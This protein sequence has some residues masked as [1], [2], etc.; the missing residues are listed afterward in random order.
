MMEISTGV[1]I[2][3]TSARVRDKIWERVVLLCKNGSAVMVFPAANEQG[4]KFQIHGETWEPIDFDGI[5][6]MLRPSAF[7]LKQI[8]FQKTGFSNAAKLRNAKKRGTTVFKQKHCTTPASYTVIDVETTGL[9]PNTDDIIEIGAIKIKDSLKVDEFNTLVMAHK[10]IPSKVTEITGITQE[11]INT[12]GVPISD[13]IAKTITFIGNLPIVCHNANFDRNFIVEACKK[14]NIPF[15][16]T[17]IDTLIL[18]RS[19]I[20]GLI[21]YKLDTLARHFSII[22]DNPHRSMN[23]CEVTWQLYEKLIKLHQE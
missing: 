23:D 8:N 20:K 18:A 17:T 6:L 9:N 12:L 5:K 2:G 7:R 14:E 10:P 19:A 11:K 22:N 15:E 4:L 16:P 21:N 3:R 13:A 1:F